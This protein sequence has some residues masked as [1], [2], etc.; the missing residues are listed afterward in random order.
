MWTNTSARNSTRTICTSISSNITRLKR[1][2]NLFIRTKVFAETTCEN[3]HIPDS[4]RRACSGSCR[5]RGC[6]GSDDGGC[7]RNTVSDAAGILHSRGRSR[8]STCLWHYCT[9]S[10]SGNPARRWHIFDGGRRTAARGGFGGAVA[11]DS[12]HAIAGS[13]RA[14]AH[15]DTDTIAH[16]DGNPDPDRG[17]GA[18]REGDKETS[19]NA[20]AHQQTDKHAKGNT[21]NCAGDDVCHY[22]RTN[23]DNSAHAGADRNSRADFHTGATERIRPVQRGRCAACCAR[24]LF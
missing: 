10:V 23:G 19:G 18:D 14:A 1:G 6:G 7:A 4:G 2:R 22:A 9:F 5:M 20:K 3:N 12:A 13:Y 15:A 17:A 24:G 8:G 16:A 21:N 11:D